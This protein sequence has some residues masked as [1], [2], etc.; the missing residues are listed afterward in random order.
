MARSQ[1]LLKLFAILLFGSFSSLFV[2]NAVAAPITAVS[3]PNNH[4]AG[5]DTF[6]KRDNLLEYEDFQDGIQTE[7]TQAEEINHLDSFIGDLGKALKII[8]KIIK[9]IK[10]GPKP[11]LPSTVY[12]SLAA[13]EAVINTQGKPVVFF[14]NAVP[15]DAADRFAQVGVDGVVLSNAFPKLFLKKRTDVDDPGDKLYTEFL[16]RVSLALANKSADTV[17]LVTSKAGPM[18]DRTWARIEEPALHANPA[19]K[20]IIRVDSE[21]TRNRDPNYWVRG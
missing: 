9:K 7:A 5:P 8:P 14:S 20:R 21:D 10:P 19:V 4:L 13:C 6:Y 16:D 12:P 11:K 1:L 17:Y 3:I 15:R 18:A 2:R